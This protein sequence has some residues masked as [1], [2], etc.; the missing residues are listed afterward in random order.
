MNISRLLHNRSKLTRLPCC[1]N[2][3]NNG[4]IYNATNGNWNNNN[5]NNSNNVLPFLEYDIY[6]DA[7]LNAYTYPYE[8]FLEAYIDSRRGKRNKVRRKKYDFMYILDLANL[9]HRVNNF[10]YIP[11][12]CER[13]VADEQKKPREIISSDVED[14]IVYQL[15]GD[16]VKGY[17]NKEIPDNSFSCR[18]GKGGLAMMKYMHDMIYDVSLGY[19]RRCWLF[20]FDLRRC[21]MSID[22]AFA[23]NDLNELANR[24]VTDEDKRNLLTYLN[25]IIFQASPDEDCVTISHPYRM[26]K[27]AYDKQ[28]RNVPRGYGLALG[29][30]PSQLY[31]NYSTRRHL[32]YMRQLH[33]PCA[34]YTDDT[35]GIVV[36]DDAQNPEGYCTKSQLLY[37]M[38]EIA[39]NLRENMHLQMH[40]DKF[41]FQ[42]LERGMRCLAY[43]FIGDKII[44]NKTIVGNLLYKT[45]CYADAADRNIKYA[46][47]NADNI[48]SVVNS[49][50]GI[51]KW[52]DSNS[53]R[54]KVMWRIKKSRLGEIF[55]V[56]DGNYK[57]ERKENSKK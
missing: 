33:I 25:R 5:K 16:E 4:I 55:D 13:F 39:R 57:I 21:F 53:L 48:M 36:D 35:I 24:Y 56:P 19:S 38:P 12:R 15:W 28:M 6:D 54:K 49:Y 14:C 3:A 2:N 26:E 32:E 50:M 43:R 51:L 10:E 18:E 42:P 45:K 29:K 11:R 8:R 22:R 9:T 30:W 20:I 44:P 7:L 31:I 46:R 37:L 1:E 40:P 27:I 41:Y 23:V 17:M 34:L 47:R 52:C